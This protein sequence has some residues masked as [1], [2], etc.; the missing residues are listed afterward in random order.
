MCKT[1]TRY[2]IMLI[3]QK[4]SFMAFMKEKT[5]AELFLSTI[6]KLYNNQTQ[7]GLILNFV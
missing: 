4:I 6:L 2:K 1:E 3:K 7:D 5:I